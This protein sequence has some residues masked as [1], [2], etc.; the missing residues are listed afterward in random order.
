MDQVQYTIEQQRSR[1]DASL[2]AERATTDSGEYRAEAFSLQELDDLLER[3]RIIADAQLLRLRNSADRQLARD[4]FESPAKLG[5]EVAQERRIADQGK[6]IE[7]EAIDARVDDERARADLLVDAERKKQELHRTNLEERR[8]DTDDQ[9][10]SERHKSDSAVAAFGVTQNALADSE[11]QKGHYGD[12]LGIVTHDL[13]GP[14]AVIT[15]SAEAIAAETHE[16]STRKLAQLVT[17]SAARMERLT[18][19]LLDAIRIQS[20]ALHITP[21]MQALDV[22][23]TEVRKSYGPLFASR[24]LSFTVNMPAKPIVASFDYDRIVQVLSNL[25]G[26]AIKFTPRGRMVMLTVEQH[27]EQVEFSLCDNG[28]GIMPS[29]LPHIF[30]RFWHIDSDTRRGLGLGLH[31]CKTIVEA[32]GGSIEVQSELGKGS[33]LRFSLPLFKLSPSAATLS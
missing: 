30:D 20:G 17:Q 3:D 22:L 27:A 18:A 2:D 6:R 33:T 13:R 7:R 31:I 21:R 32:H 14:L 12:V 15:M 1:T 19:D 10:S 16:P 29:D 24:G 25:L 28:P 26:N 9:L 8:Q 4:R 23:L 5:G 11:A